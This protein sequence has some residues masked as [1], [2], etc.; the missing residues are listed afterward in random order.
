MKRWLRKMKSLLCWIRH[1]FVR[2]G[3]T[4]VYICCRCGDFFI[5]KYY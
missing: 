5:S 1:D 3:K 4:R 2:V